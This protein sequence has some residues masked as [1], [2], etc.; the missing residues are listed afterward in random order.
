MPETKTKI[1]NCHYNTARLRFAV[2]R[3]CPAMT[4][5]GRDTL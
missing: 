4:K 3:S 1:S 2:E 5:K